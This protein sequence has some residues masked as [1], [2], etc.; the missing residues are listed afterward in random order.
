MRLGPG[1]FILIL[2]P[3]GTV[4]TVSPGDWNQLLGNLAFPA[5]PHTDD[6]GRLPVGRGAERQPLAH[7]ASKALQKGHFL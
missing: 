5:H 7:H 1:M 6:L 4:D 3:E 2:L